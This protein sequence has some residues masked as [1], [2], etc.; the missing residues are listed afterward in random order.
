MSR[1][2]PLLLLLICLAASPAFGRADL[3]ELNTRHYHIH[4]DLD[5]TLA[6]DLGL[7]MDAMYDE[8]SQ[9]LA[10]FKGSGKVPPLE[11]Y[12]FHHERD[13][14]HFTGGRLRNS[15]GVFLPT[16]NSL[17]AFLDGPGRDQLRRNLQHEAFHQFAFNG[18]SPGLPV[19]LNEG[20]AQFFEEGLWN[21]DGFVLGEAPPRRIR[22]LQADL[23]GDRVIEF[24][25]LLSMTGEQWARRLSASREDGITQYNQSWAM[26][27]FLVMTENARGEFIYRPRLLDML[28]QLHD[29]KEPDEAFRI[30][31]GGNV[32]AFQDR[33]LEYAQ[34]L[35][36]TPEAS[37]IENQGVLADMLVDFNHNGKRFDSIESF[38]RFVVRGRYRMH[39]T[40]GEL[41]WDTSPDMNRYFS[42]LTGNLFSAAD[43]YFSVRS[44]SPLP[45]IVCRYGDQIVLRTRFYDAEQDTIDH[46]MLIEPVRASASIR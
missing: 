46:E 13:Y 24:G 14:T 25:K 16:R 6:R 43:L 42:D 10:I 26:V 1:R 32:R 21:G 38:R 35:Q 22:Q 3:H 5:D 17:A 19:W 40:R 11:V 9:R 37:L 15:G 18:I 27:H 30:A 44:G 23:K 39:Y 29:G 20:L 4:T 36:P 7:R 34:T 8:Y 31:F 41:Q 28:R 12:L 2:N 45:D 33:F